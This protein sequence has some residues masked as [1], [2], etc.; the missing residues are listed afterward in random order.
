MLRLGIAMIPAQHRIA[1]AAILLFITGCGDTLLLHPTTHHFDALGAQRLTFEHNGKRIEI[2]SALSP[3]A[4][5][6]GAPEAYMLY[7]PGN[8]SR[9]ESSATPLAKFWGARPVEVWAMN[10]PGFGLS[11]GPTALSSIEATALATYDELALRA[12]GRTIFVT[13]YSLGSTTA[14][15][16]AVHR[17]TAGM[18]LQ[19]PPPLPRVIMQRYG[20]WNLWLLAGTTVLQL[21]PDL[22]SLNTSPHIKAPALFILSGSDTLIPL[23]YQQ[24]VVNAY[25]GDKQI[26]LQP[27]ANHDTPLAPADQLRLQSNLDWLWARTM[28]PT[29][30]R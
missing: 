27:N 9:A 5:A 13:G 18:I 19:S 14:L 8:A 15:A 30:Q 16:V 24:L 22:N 6:A 17:P 2:Y 12:A 21:P 25:A 29:A 11:D 7:F 26:L 10:Y 1:L 20:W 23:E 3:G 4:I 28:P